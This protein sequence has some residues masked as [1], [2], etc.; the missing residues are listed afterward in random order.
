MKVKE[1]LEKGLIK[2]QPIDK[3]EIAGS[4]AL[5]QRFLERAKGNMELNFYD[6]TFLLAYTSMFHAARALLFE[7][8][9]KERSHLA[10]VEALKE[11]YAH[12]KDIVDFMNTLDSYR[13]TRHAIQYSGELSNELDAIQS[14]KDAEKL[15]K[16]VKKKLN[17]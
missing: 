6:I 5:A 7:K 2:G 1:L 8:G 14:L 13:L 11:L 4:I 10:L 3:A 9:Y 15:M 12:D 17:L 16:I